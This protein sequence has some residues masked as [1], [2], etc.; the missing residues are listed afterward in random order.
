MTNLEPGIIIKF[1]HHHHHQ[2]KF[3]SFKSINMVH[4]WTMQT[5]KTFH[6]FQLYIRYYR[7]YFGNV[8]IKSFLQPANTFTH[9]VKMKKKKKSQNWTKKKGLQHRNHDGNFSC[10][11]CGT[12]KQWNELIENPCEQNDDHHSSW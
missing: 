7:F 3:Q 8:L 5:K 2:W 4:I 10:C 6:Q 11:L 12:A 1:H 9:N